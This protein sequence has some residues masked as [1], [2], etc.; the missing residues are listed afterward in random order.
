V[1]E[2]IVFGLK[3]KKNKAF[4]QKE[5]RGAFFIVRLLTFNFKIGPSFQL[6]RKAT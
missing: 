4:S 3:L 5:G 1:H 6:A 2:K